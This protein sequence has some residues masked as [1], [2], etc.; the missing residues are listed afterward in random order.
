VFDF[1]AVQAITLV[2]D[3][4][5]IAVILSYLIPVTPAQLPRLVAWIQATKDPKEDYDFIPLGVYRWGVSVMAAA[6][7]GF[8]QYLMWSSLVI[9][10]TWTLAYGQGRLI[11]FFLVE[12]PL[13]VWAITV[14]LLFRRA[15]RRST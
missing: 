11:G 3:G 15:A 9:D 14:F 2:M 5:C 6:I 7:I 13:L 1:I 8:T 12:V 10:P 4:Y